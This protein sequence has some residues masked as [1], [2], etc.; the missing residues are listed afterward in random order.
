MTILQPLHFMQAVMNFATA[1]EGL[2]RMGLVTSL[3]IGMCGREN[4][5]GLRGHTVFP[6]SIAA[7]L[8]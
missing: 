6:T 3:V 4:G 1:A 5:G 2:N 8:N 7:F